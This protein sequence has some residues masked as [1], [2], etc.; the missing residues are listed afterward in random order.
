[1]ETIHHVA[2]QVDDIGE[3]VAWYRQQ[4]VC[5]V[6][7]QE[8]TWALLSFDN[9]NIALVLPGQHP[10]HIRMPRVDANHIGP[11]AA[12]RDGTAHIKD[13]SGNSPHTLDPQSR[14]EPA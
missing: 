12:H 1:M 11:L 8:A 6:K 2:L 13:P 14:K 4:F 10:P 7:H 5:E 3:A 9:T